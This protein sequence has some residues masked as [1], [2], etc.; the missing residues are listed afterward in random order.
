MN[1]TVECFAAAAI[2]SSHDNSKFASSGGDRSVFL[3]DVMTGTTIRRIAGHLGKI[4]TV[5]FNE[6]ASVVASGLYAFHASLSSIHQCL[7]QGHT[8]PQC[9]SGI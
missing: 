5:E 8:T 4:F 9:D 2:L 1:L 6:D 3:W 7:R